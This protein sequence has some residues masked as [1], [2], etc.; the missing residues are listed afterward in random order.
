[1]NLLQRIDLACDA[2]DLPSLRSE[3]YRVACPCVVRGREISCVVHHI[4]QENV[5]PASKALRIGNH[6]RF[7]RKSPRK[8]L[9]IRGILVAFGSEAFRVQHRL[10]GGS[11][12]RRIWGSGFRLFLE[13]F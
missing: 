8:I 3:M 2:L 7:T 10:R 4:E 6:R 5:S 9:I 11:H 12:G 13:P 1:M